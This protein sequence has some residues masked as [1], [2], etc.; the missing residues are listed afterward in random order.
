MSSIYTP[1]LEK[2]KD[3]H[4]SVNAAYSTY[5]GAGTSS[6]PIPS[7][8]P[9]TRPSME[10]SRSSSR[11]SSTSS[12]NK[13]WSTIKKAAREHH[14]SVNAAYTTYYGAG[15][16]GTPSVAPAP[17]SASLSPSLDSSI[18]VD[19]IELEKEALRME[20]ERKERESAASKA[21]KKVKEAA[22]EH[23]RSVNQAY[24]VY[25]GQGQGR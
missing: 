6:S 25:Y 22:K 20:E 13:A 7:A 14:E 11:S 21:W 2:V 8:P 9:S 15:F 10:S 18:S 23:H 3:H 19:S 24:A 5:Y 12:I 4:R 16:T 17:R 1:L